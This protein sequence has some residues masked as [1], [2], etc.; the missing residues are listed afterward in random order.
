MLVHLNVNSL[1]NKLESIADVT[2]GTLDIFFLSETKIDKSLPD[3][4][5]FLNNF[6]IFRKDRNR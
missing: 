2:Q 3:K 1:R 5:F 6:R 4:Q